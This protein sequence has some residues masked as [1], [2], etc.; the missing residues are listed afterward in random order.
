MQDRDGAHRLLALLRERFST[1]SLVWASSAR[2]A[3]TRATCT[4]ATGRPAPRSCSP[5][6]AADPALTLPE[7]DFL[8][9]APDA[10]A[11][12]RRVAARISRRHRILAVWL[13]AVLA[14]ALLTALAIWQAYADNA[15]RRTQ[16]AARQV[17][18]VADALRTTDPRTALLLG[19][20][21]WTRGPG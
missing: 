7:R 10:R 1:I 2:S 20:A 3:M 17:A 14:V 9:A 8:S 11:A 13:S 19:A 12:E 16:E 18:D 4:G 21:A 5:D 6:H 15:R